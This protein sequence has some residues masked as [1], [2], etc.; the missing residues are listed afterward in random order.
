MKLETQKIT[1]LV[2]Y[3]FKS[4]ITVYR[5]TSDSE[6]T[7]KDSK[8]THKIHAE[9]FIHTCMLSDTHIQSYRVNRK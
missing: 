3:I 8:H 4:S 6:P 5:K 7:F 2:V 1:F 9:R